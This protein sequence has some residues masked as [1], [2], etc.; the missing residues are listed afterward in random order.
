[1]IPKTIPRSDPFLVLWSYLQILSPFAI[2]TLLCFEAEDIFHLLS[3]IHSFL[4][5]QEDNY[6]PVRPFR[7]SF[8]DF[9]VD[10]AR[11]ANP[12]FH[13]CP[14]DRYTELLVGCLELPMNRR[15]EQNI[16]KLPTGVTNSEVDDLEERTG[17]H[18]DDALQYACKRSGL[19]M[20][21]P[22]LMGGKSLEFVPRLQN[23]GGWVDTEPHK[24][25]TFMV[26]PSL[27][28]ERTI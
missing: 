14:L 21:F 13:V 3:S 4:I 16:Y 6:H 17:E 18:F 27:E 1:M 19:Q 25:A 10:P 9:I 5:L 22:P 12:R 20:K 15:L 8:V 24:E 26:A 7:K 11:C 23:N 28:V 2:A